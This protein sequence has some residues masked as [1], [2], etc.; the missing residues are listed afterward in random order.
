MAAW[1][2][3]TL[4]VLTKPVAPNT[5]A[6]VPILPYEAQPVGALMVAQVLVTSDRICDSVHVAGTVKLHVT[7][8]KPRLP[9]DMPTQS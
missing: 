8:V 6:P 2:C 9:A 4:R 5:P 1:I 3:S 7:K